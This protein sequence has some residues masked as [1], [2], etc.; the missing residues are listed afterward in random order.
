MPNN[1]E[2]IARAVRAAINI[3]YD[4]MPPETIEAIVASVVASL[5]G[6]PDPR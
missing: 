4:R 5:I 2:T 3:H 6:T 1:T